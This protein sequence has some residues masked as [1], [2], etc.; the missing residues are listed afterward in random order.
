M[1]DCITYMFQVNND[2]G[3]ARLG[4]WCEGPCGLLLYSLSILLVSMIAFVI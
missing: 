2:T 1:L 3:H 4:D